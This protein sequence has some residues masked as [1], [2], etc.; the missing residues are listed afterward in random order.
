[1]SEEY[2]EDKKRVFGMDQ[3]IFV[4]DP[5]LH[6]D[7]FEFLHSPVRKFNDVLCNWVSKSL[8]DPNLPWLFFDPKKKHSITEA[9][10]KGEEKNDVLDVGPEPDRVQLT[11]HLFLI[12][13]FQRLQ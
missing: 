11:V 4:S 5:Q 2:E 12:S 9:K 10:E 1:M 3:I 7:Y 8:D 6:P 13:H